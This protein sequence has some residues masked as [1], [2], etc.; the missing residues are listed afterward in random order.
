MGKVVVD[1]LTVGRWV[2]LA[3]KGAEDLTVDAILVTVVVSDLAWFWSSF[4][5]YVWTHSCLGSAQISLLS[6]VM[7]LWKER[8]HGQMKSNDWM[9]REYVGLKREVRGKRELRVTCSS[10]RF[11]RTNS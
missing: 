5:V 4:L 9:R 3:F 10:C 2:K 6:L 1:A 7:K 8:R 11:S